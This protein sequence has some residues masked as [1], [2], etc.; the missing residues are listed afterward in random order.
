MDAPSGQTNRL[1][2]LHFSDST[3]GWTRSLSVCTGTGISPRRQPLTDPAI[4]PRT[5]K[6]FST[7]NT[8][9]GSTMATNAPEV[10][11]CQF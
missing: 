8:V 9:T 11:R 6:R 4:N 5:K 7:K 2:E 10:S 1:H 3:T